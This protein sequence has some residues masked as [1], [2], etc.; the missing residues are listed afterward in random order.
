M[1][2]GDFWYRENA[3]SYAIKDTTGKPLRL[4][5]PPLA[6][7]DLVPLL[8]STAYRAVTVR[9]KTSWTFPRAG[10]IPGRG[11]VRRVVSCEHAAVTGTSAVLVTNRV[12]WSAQRIMALSVPRW[13]IEIS[14]PYYGSRA[15]LS[16][17]AA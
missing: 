5:G 7:A 10:R 1:S 8:P 2:N 6:V 4:E 16:L 3:I 15:S 13:P 17:A 9:D 14:Q 12:D 11:N